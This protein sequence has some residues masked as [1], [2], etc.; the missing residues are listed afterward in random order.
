MSLKMSKSMSLPGHQKLQT[1]VQGAGIGHYK[2]HA[3]VDLCAGPGAH[4][5]ILGMGRR[6][7]QL[8]DSKHRVSKLERRG[9]K[10]K[11][12]NATNDRQLANPRLY[13]P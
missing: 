11:R 4:E 3:I 7:V 2:T 9:C 5:A 12:A 1:R 13:S 10:P 6:V 8:R